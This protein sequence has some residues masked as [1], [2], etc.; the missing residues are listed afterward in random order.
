M[1]R[2][3]SLVAVFLGIG[4]VVVCLAYSFFDRAEGG[5]QITDRFRTTMSEPGLRA[6]DANFQTIKGLGDGFLGQ[7]APN[8]AR[9]LRVT[10]AQFE[11][12]AKA[13]FPAVGQ[14]YDAVPPAIALVDPVIPR[15]E[16]SRR[17]FEQVDDIPGLGLPIVAV[18]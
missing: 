10:P 1:S 5:E 11:A 8:F 4:L 9:A 17:D 6:L 7:A 3:V 2:L 18:P 12:F 15:L 14:A 13:N 16:A